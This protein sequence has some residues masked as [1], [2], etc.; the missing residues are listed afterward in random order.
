M[1]SENARFIGS[2]GNEFERI[3]KQ[4]SEEQV[5]RSDYMARRIEESALAHICENSRS[6]TEKAS[7]KLS[8][9]PDN[10]HDLSE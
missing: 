2:K 8:R 9:T 10:E 3:A 6:A 5:D 1:K 7:T 4:K